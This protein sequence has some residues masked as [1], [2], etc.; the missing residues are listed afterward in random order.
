MTSVANSVVIPLSALL[1]AEVPPAHWLGTTPLLDLSDDRLRV[2]AKA[3]TQLSK[4]DRERALAIYNYVKALPFGY[5]P[6]GGQATARQVIDAGYGSSYG[7]ST[8]FVALLRLAG[9]PARIRMVQLRGD[10]L[11]GLYDTLPTINHALV[12]IWLDDHWVRTDAHAFDTVYVA[13]ARAALGQRDW[14]RGYCIVRNAHNLWNGRD[15]AFCA[16]SMDDS[17]RMP[18]ADFGVFNDPKEFVTDYGNSPMAHAMGILKGVQF[19]MVARVLNRGIRKLRKQEFAA[20]AV[21]V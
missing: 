2:R 4:N 19:Q 13:A 7:K 17:D 18:L 10:L 21:T 12:E 14:D 20:Q 8:L 16:L 1:R 6:L 9:L 11:R 5:L 15:D 3:L